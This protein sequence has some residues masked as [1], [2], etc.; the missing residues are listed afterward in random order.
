MLWSVRQDRPPFRA[1]VPCGGT[2]PQ[3]QRLR[4]KFRSRGRRRNRA[5]PRLKQLRHRRALCTIACVKYDAPQ[6]CDCTIH[7]HPPPAERHETCNPLFRVV[8]CPP[9]D[10][11]RA[12]LAPER[13]GY[14]CLHDQHSARI[15]H[16][17]AVVELSTADIT[18]SRR[19][20]PRLFPTLWR[21]RDVYSRRNN[22][23]CDWTV[24][25]IHDEFWRRF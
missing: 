11:C 18:H 22:T 13:P 25:R 10:E 15:L 16:R 24:Y 19:I 9:V 4:L 7:A 5:V 21:Y 2:P 1:H 17:P 6:S 14:P 12:D 8:A 20:H 23:W 3:T